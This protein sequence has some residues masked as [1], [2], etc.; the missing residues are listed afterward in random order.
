M[1]TE[2]GLTHQQERFAQCVASGMS[3]A[4]AYREA[5][6][7]ANTWRDSSVW[8]K[9]SELSANAKVSGRIAALRAELA[10]K[11][12]WTREQSVTVLSGIAC[13]A[14]KC[15]DRVSAVKELNAM[16]GF[17]APVKMDV[18]GMLLAAVLPAKGGSDDC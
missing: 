5:Y 18:H 7:R 17:N 16:H 8:V 12:L 3:Q 2:R 9:A 6:P 11:L 14:E 15:S 13:G 1:R 4:A 10:A